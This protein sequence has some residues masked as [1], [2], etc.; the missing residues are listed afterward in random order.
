MRWLSAASVMETLTLADFLDMYGFLAA[1]VADQLAFATTL[2]EDEKRDRFFLSRATPKLLADVSKRLQKARD[3]CES[4]GL[5]HSL[6]A[7]ERLIR[8]VDDETGTQLSLSRLIEDLYGVRDRIEDELKHRHFY[9]VDPE[10]FKYFREAQEILSQEALRAFPSACRD[11]EEA[12]K[13]FALGRYT[14]CVFHAMRV[15]EHGMNALAL[16]LGLL[17]PY[18]TW[19][20]KIEK[21]VAVL[22]DELRKPYSPTSV[23]AGRLEFFKQATERLTAVQ[24]AL[25]NET[26][27]ARSYYGREDAEDVYRSTLRLMEK[28]AEKLAEAP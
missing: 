25:R 28:L 20:K 14:A 12:S 26:M 10:H 7:L 9:Y 11:V 15:M 27:H 2:L 5:Q 6:D 17:Q 18:R 4:L 24:H 21:M 16:E 22:V 19:D 23:L 8:R 1:S 3:F 13:C